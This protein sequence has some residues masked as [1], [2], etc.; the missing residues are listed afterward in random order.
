M[1]RRSIIIF[2]LL[3]VV[4]FSA[5]AIYADARQLLNSLLVVSPWYWVGTVALMLLNLLFRFVRWHYFLKVVGVSA[6]VKT[7][8][9]IFMAS[10][11][12]IMMPG[13]VGELAK[14]VF[15]AAAWHLDYGK[16]QAE[17]A[18]E[19]K[20]ILVYFTRSYAP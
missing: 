19:D 10:L 5:L 20:L 16:A 12:F 2:T 7:S 17:A 14:P 4:V 15:Q 8:A 6:P 3:T 18:R 1:K 9:L 13:R 11:S